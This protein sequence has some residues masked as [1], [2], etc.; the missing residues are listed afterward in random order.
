MALLASQQSIVERLMHNASYVEQLQLLS[1][2][3]GSGKTTI[4]TAIS[5]QSHEVK[6]AFVSCPEYADDTEIRRKIW[7][8]LL[9]EPVFDDDIPLADM[10]LAVQNTITQPLL[11]LVDDAHRLSLPLLAELMTLS[12]MQAIHQPISVIASVPPAFIENLD[13]DLTADTDVYTCLHIEPLSVEEQYNL[14]LILLGQQTDRREQSVVLPDFGGVEVY[15]DEYIRA[16]NGDSSKAA[17][18]RLSPLMKVSMAS[19]TA[20]LIFLGYWGFQVS[21]QQKP[22]AKDT[23]QT[24][25][26]IDATQLTYS[27]SPVVSTNRPMDS[28]VDLPMS[29]PTQ[30]TIEVQTKLEPLVVDEKSE[31]KQAEE[32]QLII[33]HNSS[34]EHSKGIV[35]KSILEKKEGKKQLQP[36]PSSREKSN[37]AKLKTEIETPK[38]N[39]SRKF[40]PKYPE[41]YT[42][43]LA[44]M[45]QKDSLTK[46]LKKLDSWK[47]IRVAKRN[48]KWVVVL[49]DFAT[50]NQAQ[51]TAN[52]LKAETKLSAPWLRKWSALKE[53]DFR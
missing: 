33:K 28:V 2:E 12:Q 37:S 49:G 50:R 15:P 22:S 34:I 41:G 46:L 38:N 9:D 32:T 39:E 29:K 30:Q 24:Q 51:K 1:G 40:S 20:L 18:I 16:F 23:T 13:A 43:Q 3:T 27:S 6:C 8:Q 36:Q 17:S 7:I 42:L 52:K 26:V 45:S 48:N 10:W 4:L 44:T 11:I 19:I 53:Y 5:Q 47:N 14:Y 21:Y 31:D 35:S 25:T